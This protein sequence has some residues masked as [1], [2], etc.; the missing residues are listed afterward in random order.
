VKACAY[1]NEIDPFA[2]QWL[3]NLIAA[4]HI[5][6]GD[7]DERSII[8]VRGD[9]L[10]GYRQCH[11]FAGI[12]VWS[13]A[14][15]KAGW[16]DDRPVWTGSCPC[17]PFSAAGRSGG[18]GDE[19]HLWPHF[20][21]LIKE[22]GIKPVFG[23]QVASADGLAWLDFVCAD[24]EAAGY[25]VGTVDT[26]A[27]G[28]G[29]PHIRQRIYFVAD[30]EDANGG[31]GER[32]EK[33]G[34]RENGER[35]RR[36]SGGGAISNLANSFDLRQSAG[37]GL[38]QDDGTPS[39]TEGEERQQ[40]VRTDAGQLHRLGDP[41]FKGLERHCGH[42][43]D[44][45]EPGRIGAFETRPAAAPGTVNGFWWGA[46]WIACIDG[47][48]RPIKPGLF[49]LVNGYPNRVGV[50]RAAGNAI[51]AEAAYHFIEVYREL[52]G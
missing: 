10:R 40:R 29:A 34:A 12:G 42:V 51:C 21:R 24:L 13:Y 4:G 43:H 9:D 50:L 11:F 2:A 45:R 46:D 16:A 32:G 6:P 41:E 31:S 5:A 7:V 19:R 47:K 20:F 26:C 1:Y 8:D 25:V 17:Q 22:S 36:S 15:R 18:F 23:E 14:L 49:P 3:R 44:G 37:A 27:A 52:R 48:S 30:A 33:E 39:C 35:W 38:G 28:F